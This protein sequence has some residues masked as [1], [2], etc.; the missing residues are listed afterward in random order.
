VERQSNQKQ[1]SRGDIRNQWCR[2]QKQRQRLKQQGDDYVLL[3]NC[4]G[5]SL[6][7]VSESVSM[8][9]HWIE[10]SMLKAK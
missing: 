6:N 4:S 3:Q 9:Y 8:A 5:F 1:L 2:L 7:N 10:S